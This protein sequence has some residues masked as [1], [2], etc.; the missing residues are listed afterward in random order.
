[1]KVLFTSSEMYPLI[2]TGGLADVSW[3][4]PQALAAN[5]ADVRIVLPAYL[6]IM[7]QIKT[8]RIAGW[9]ELLGVNRHYDARVIEVQDETLPVNLWL[10]D[11]P[12]L[13]CRAGNPYLDPDGYDW[14]DNAERFTVFSRAVAGLAVDH[15]NTGWTPDVVHSNDWQTGLVAAFLSLQSSPVIKI[16]TIHNLA[17]GGHYSH[18]EFMA[19]KLPS[20]WWSHES[21]EFY[22]GFSMLKAG[23]VFSDHVTTVSPTYAKEICT[24]D[25]GYGFEGLLH[26]RQHKL[27]GILNGI[28]SDKWNPATDSSLAANYSPG[29]D[30]ILEAKRKNRQ[31]L[32]KAFGANLKQSRSAAPVLGFIGRLVEQKGVDLL[33]Q[34]IPRLLANTTARFV[35]LG[36]GQA[37]YEQR[38]QQLSELHADR[39]F[40]HL[41]YSEPLAHQIEAGSDLFLMPSRFEPCGL[42]QLYSL[43]YGTPPVVHKTGGLADTV[44]HASAEALH[45]GTATGFVFTRQH[46]DALYDAIDY[47]LSLRRRPKVWKKLVQNAMH[48]HFDW[49]DSAQQYLDL[50]QQYEAR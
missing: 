6:D 4:L 17:Y 8:F 2:K 13:Y 48:Q 45:Q 10:I 39:V 16:F 12:E 42:N 9:L 49:Q 47:A 38:L 33:L 18:D 3:S 28:D 14:P 43:R 23:I 5:G 37:D 34:V 44:V 19:L 41:G 31:A 26:S 35:V 30:D 27:T 29:Q 25:F 36:S 32:L 46:A 7:K 21:L 15:A 22:S 11:I 20:E 24:A 1:M 50:Y 40:L